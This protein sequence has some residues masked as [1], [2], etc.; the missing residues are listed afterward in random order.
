[1]QHLDERIAEEVLIL[2]VVKAPRH[3]LQVGGKMLHRDFMPRTDNAALEQRERRF[4]CVRGHGQAAF[5][6]NI[7]VF[8]VI[9]FL[10][11]GLMESRGAEVVELRFVGHDYVNGFVHVAGDDLVDL[12]LVQVR[13]RDEVEAAAALTNANHGRVL[14]PLI[15]VLGVTADVHLINFH[16]ARE[17]VLRLFH[18]LADAMAEVPRGFVGDAEHSLDLISGDAFARFGHQVGNEKPLRQRQMGVMED[19]SHGHGELI[20]A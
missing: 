3:L 2:A 1:M 6:S 7:L 15:R 14:L 8:R 16:G 9:H 4:D 13:G 20:A 11:L 5:I 17:F 19:R 12:V 18:G 10:V